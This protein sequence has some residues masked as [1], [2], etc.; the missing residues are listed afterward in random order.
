MKSHYK[1]RTF[2]GDVYPGDAP[3]NEE[4]RD[5]GME[6]WGGQLVRLIFQYHLIFHTNLLH[7]T[8]W[9]LVKEKYYLCLRFGIRAAGPGGCPMEGCEKRFLFGYSSEFCV[10]GEEWVSL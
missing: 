4:P 3:E 1:A 2:A 7:V 6:L 5:M 8:N 9:T 10:L